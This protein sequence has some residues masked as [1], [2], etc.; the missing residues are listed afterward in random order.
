M[1]KVEVQNFHKS[2]NESCYSSEQ[3]AVIWD[4]YVTHSVASSVSLRREAK[5]YEQKKFPLKEMKCKA[6]F[7]EKNDRV[8]LA[9]SMDRTVEEMEM[10]TTIGNGNDKR[11]N[12]IDISNPK[13]ICTTPYTISDTDK[14]KAKYGEA[15]SILTHIRNSFAHGNTY[16]FD[17]K[18]M[19]LEDKAR[20]NN[21]KTTAMILIRMQTL[22]DWIKIIDAQGKYY[23][24]PI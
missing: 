23:N 15:E 3:I 10:H 18:M 24:F 19:L 13:L 21:G 16:F 11:N 7:A 14:P 17:N 2:I 1:A 8:L 5:D 12:P 20:G 22:I 9:D 4:F 6:E